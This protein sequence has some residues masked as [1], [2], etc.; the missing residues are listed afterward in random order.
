MVVGTFFGNAFLEIGVKTD[1]FWIWVFQ[2]CWHL[3]SSTFTAS[4]F[5]IWNSSAGSPSPPLALFIATLPKAHLTSHSRMFG[6][7]GVTSAL[8]LSRSQRPFSYSVSVYSCHLFLIISVS[9]SS[10][11]YLSFIV[12][13]FSEMFPWYLQFLEEFSSLSH[14]TV[15]LYFFALSLEKGLLMSPCCSLKLCLPL[16][17]SSP[18]PLPFTFLLSSTICEASS[19]N[20]GGSDSKNLPAMQEAWVRSLGC[21]DP[22][23]E[24]MATCWEPAQEIPPMTRSCGEAWWARRVRSW[25]VLCLSIYPETKICLF[26]LCYTILFWH[27]HLFSGKS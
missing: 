26:T 25:G 21:K 4:S 14:S 27:Y 20:P 17:L 1:L 5:R 12:L 23:E 24:G 13:V 7:R 2:I 9:L 8:W 6:S 10:L 11:L 16:G 22:L 3:E 15:F 19:D 18:S